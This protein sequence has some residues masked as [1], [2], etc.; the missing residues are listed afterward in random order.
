MRVRLRQRSAIVVA[1]D[2][3]IANIHP[4]SGA[5]AETTIDQHLLNLE[6]GGII[7][8]WVR[9]RICLP[10]IW[11]KAC[12]GCPVFCCVEKIGYIENY[13]FRYANYVGVGGRFTQPISRHRHFVRCFSN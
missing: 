11:Q 2:G 8:A 6:V 7:H 5:Q 12:D 13:A 1:D 3:G 9:R 10:L 4:H